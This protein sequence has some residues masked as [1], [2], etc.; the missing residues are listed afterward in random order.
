MNPSPNFI[1]IFT[2]IVSPIEFSTTT[3]FNT[4]LSELKSKVN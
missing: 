1:P 4:Y 2:H 3:G